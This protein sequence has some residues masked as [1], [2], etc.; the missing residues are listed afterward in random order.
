VVRPKAT[1]NFGCLIA[2]ALFLLCNGII[3]LTIIHDLNGL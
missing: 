3:I 2:L 1:T